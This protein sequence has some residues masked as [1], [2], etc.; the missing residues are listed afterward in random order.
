[1]SSPSGWWNDSRARTPAYQTWSWVQ[2]LYQYSN[3]LLFFGTIL[4]LDIYIFWIGIWTTGFHLRSRHSTVWGTSLY[5]PFLCWLLIGADVGFSL[6]PSQLCHFYPSTSSMFWFWFW[7]HLYFVCLGLFIKIFIFSFSFYILMYLFVYW[8]DWELNTEI[9]TCKTR[10]LQLEPYIQL[11]LLW[12]IRRW[13]FLN[14]LLGLWSNNDSSDIN[15]QGS[16]DNRCESSAPVYIF[17]FWNKLSRLA[18]NS[19]SYCL[20]LPCVP[21]HSAIFVHF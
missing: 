1:M 16:K 10:A 18:W 15:L 20:H 13:G 3:F 12:L 9:H 19:W 14:Y 7:F 11:I 6:N 5:I 21:T 17:D 2:I 4:L 8:W